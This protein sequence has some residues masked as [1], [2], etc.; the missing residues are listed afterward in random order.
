ML[1]SICSYRSNSHHLRTAGTL[2]WASASFNKTASGPSPTARFRTLQAL[3]QA[4]DDQH[5]PVVVVSEDSPSWQL[6]QKGDTCGGSALTSST[7][8]YSLNLYD[9]V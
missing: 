6:S 8:V 9:A 1:P 2:Y 5:E 3:Q 7:S 4:W